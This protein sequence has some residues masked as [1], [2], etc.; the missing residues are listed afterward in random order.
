MKIYSK[1]P[2]F[3]CDK[4]G[5]YGYFSIF[6]ELNFFRQPFKQFNCLFVKFIKEILLFKHNIIFTRPKNSLQT[7]YFIY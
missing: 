7:E 1:I 2:I 3:F 6:A 4:K 5:R